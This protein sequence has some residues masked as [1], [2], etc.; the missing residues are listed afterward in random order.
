MQLRSPLANPRC[1]SNARGAE[2]EREFARPSLRHERHYARMIA[3]RRVITAPPYSSPPPSLE[4]VYTCASG[5][6]GA[7]EWHSN[8]RGP[9]GGGMPV[10]LHR[11]FLQRASP[12][13]FQ[14]LPL[15]HRRSAR[16]ILLV[17][18]RAVRGNLR[19][20]RHVRAVHIDRLGQEGG[21]EEGGSHALARSL[22][23]SLYTGLVE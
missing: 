14:S 3:F 21:G 10:Y 4:H 1:S 22:S 2:G 9:R 11:L 20:F 18:R 13:S 17:M 12:H 8:N 16:E 6:I 15:L 7:N 23:S 19:L 5:L